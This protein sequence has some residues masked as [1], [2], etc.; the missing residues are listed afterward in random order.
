M[1]YLMGT[2]NQLFLSLKSKGK[3]V[4]R[5]LE[6][7]MYEYK[8]VVNFKKLNRLPKINKRLYDVPV[9]H[10]ILNCG[11]PT[12]EAQRLEVI[13]AASLEII[14]S[15]QSCLK[16]NLTLK[17]HVILSTRIEICKMLLTV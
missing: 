6:Y 17:T 10:V 8:K 12:E 5:Q 14:S 2:R 1:Q 13:S 11:T 3:I 4:D 15:N 9:R 16:E 7:F